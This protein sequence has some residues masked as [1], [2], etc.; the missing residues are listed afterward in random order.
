[1]KADPSRKTRRPPGFVKPDHWTA[2]PPPEPE[3]ADAEDTIGDGDHETEGGEKR[4][5]PTRYGDWTKDGI[6]IDF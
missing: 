1:M 2:A 6:A 3:P 4:V 5:S